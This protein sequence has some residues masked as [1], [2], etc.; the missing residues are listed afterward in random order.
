MGRRTDTGT[1]GAIAHGM[2]AS[3]GMLSDGTAFG[4]QVLL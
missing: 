3:C 2:V 1:M 4:K